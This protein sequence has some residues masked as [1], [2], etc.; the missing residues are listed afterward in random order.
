VKIA[1]ES[2][3]PA[4]RIVALDGWRG[5]SIL[6]VIVGHL[7]NFRYTHGGT[8]DFTYRL[9]EVLS[10]GGVC[11]F[12]SISG[13]I[14]VRF[15][16]LERARTGTFSVLAFYTRRCLRILPPLWVY[17]LAVTLL[18]ATGCIVQA[19]HQTLLAASF[20]CNLPG[21]YCG[22]FGNH[23]WSL[24]YE[25][26]FYLLMPLLMY[27]FPRRT[28]TLLLAAMLAVPALRYLAHPGH[29][30]A[31]IAHQ[32][33]YCSFICAGGV[34][35]AHA[36]RILRY[37]RGPAGTVVWVSA[38]IILIALFVLDALGQDPRAVS[39]IQHARM[40]FGGTIEP[41]AVGWLVASVCVQR[42]LL[43]RALSWRPIN[44][45]GAISFSLYLWQALFTSLPESY[46]RP[47]PLLFP[48]LML[49]CAALSYHLIERPFIQL[50]KWI[51]NR[52]ASGATAISSAAT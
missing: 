43:V 29:L 37:A 41:I 18:A 39:K 1:S 35:A 2:A 5:I 44:Y 36:E 45:I 8:E 9:F 26:Q 33:F 10:A 6:L 12:F 52:R 22:R 42:S 17:L 7:V 47:S 46:L 16:L 31:Q 50:G 32:T 25:E 13:F 20:V 40:L 4:K 38:L 24:A 30:G 11:I 14:I 34:A 15:A 49:V 28:F 27:R 21:F 48:P 51:L 23:T 3:I 19:R